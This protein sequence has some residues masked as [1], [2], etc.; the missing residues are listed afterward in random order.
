MD[1]FFDVLV[2]T[3]MQVDF[4]FE[5]SGKMDARKH[6]EIY[7]HPRSLMGVSDGGA[8]VKSFVGG[9]SSTAFL[10]W[11]VREEGRLTLEEAHNLLSQRPAEVFGF[12][13]RGVLLEGYAADIMIYDLEKLGFE[14]KYTIAYD[15]PDAGYRRTLPAQGVS[16]V[17]VNGQVIVEDSHTTDAL[18]GVVLGPTGP[19]PT[20]VSPA[21]S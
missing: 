3:K 17:L 21:A 8:H 1:V 2:A 19:S 10:I 15:L 11:L 18:P 12:T 5:L 4:R 7:R 6:V 14:R 13:D 9:G 20:T 16:H